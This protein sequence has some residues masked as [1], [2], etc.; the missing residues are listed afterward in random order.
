MQPLRVLVSNRVEVP[1]LERLRSSF[2]AVVF[3]ALPPDGTVPD[4]AQNA[5]ALLRCLMPRDVLKR[6]VETAP[7]LRWIHT[8]SAGF[9]WLMIPEVLERD[10]V[11]SRS[12]NAYNIPIAEYVLGYMLLHVKRFPELL[13]A[14]ARHAWEPP[15]PGELYERTVGIVG[16]GAIGSEIAR[17]CAAFGMRVVGIR[18][19]ARPTP[20]VDETWG[21][22]SLP[23]L[24]QESDYV[25]LASPL[26]TE[27]R[28]MIAAAQLRQMKPTALLINIARGAL[29]VEDDLLVA[30][31]E[32]RIGGAC[33]DTFEQEPLPPDSPLWSAPNMTITPHCTYRS[34]RGM[35]RVIAEF[36][37]NLER[38]IAGEELANVLGDPAL[39]Y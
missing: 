11:I 2:P 13:A 7:A 39:G 26:T 12:A 31:R 9:D 14:Q 33:L 28:G 37:A 24:L 18:R 32:G 6:T 30:L 22:E 8:C 25:V 4:E 20:F 10:L 1:D 27:T 23:R 17:R 16:A 35:E 21:P 29:I 15:M 5:S 38:F 34:P 3:T 36:S 19:T